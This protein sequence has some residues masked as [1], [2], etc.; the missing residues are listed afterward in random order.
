MEC[1][2]DFVKYNTYLVH[3]DLTETGLIEPAVKYL[4][5]LL[6]KSQGLR[7]MHLCGNKGITDESLD[8]IKK[9]IHAQSLPEPI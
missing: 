7:C 8:W 9:R 6:R 2:K 4:A 3:L 1:F 5:A